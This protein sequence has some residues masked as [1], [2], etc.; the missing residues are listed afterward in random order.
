VA[1][2]QVYLNGG[3]TAVSVGGSQVTVLSL[4]A[5]AC[6]AALARTDFSSPDDLSAALD[7]CESATLWIECRSDATPPPYGVVCPSGA[8]APA[9]ATRYQAVNRLW[10]AMNGDT[11]LYPVSFGI[12][13][14]GATKESGR[15]DAAQSLQAALASAQQVLDFG[16][17]NYLAAF[18]I[19]SYAGTGTVDWLAHY[20]ERPRYQMFATNIVSAYLWFRS[21]GDV[22]VTDTRAVLDGLAADPDVSVGAKLYIDE[23]KYNSGE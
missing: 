16:T 11:D 5:S 23:I 21:Y 2:N 9:W 7:P 14:L 15:A 10:V 3:T 4:L 13:A 19:K 6:D 17:M 20:T 18:E 12:A 22:T 8:D 1:H